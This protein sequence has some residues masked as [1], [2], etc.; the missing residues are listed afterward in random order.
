MQAGDGG[1]ASWLGTGEAVY[2]SVVLV[3]GQCRAVVK[4]R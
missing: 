1:E 4:R 3:S 2:R